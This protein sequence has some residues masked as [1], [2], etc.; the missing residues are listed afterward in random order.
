MKILVL[1]L[2]ISLVS[3]T[4]NAQA[5]AQSGANC[6]RPGSTTISSGKKYTCIKKG[7]AFVWNKGVA[8]KSRSTTTSTTT[9]PTTSTVKWQFDGKTWV[10]QGTAPACSMPVIAEGALLDFSRVKSIEQPGQVRGGSYK[11]HAAVRWSD[12]GSYVNGVSVTAPFDGEIVVAAQYKQGGNFQFLLNIIHPCGIMLR[13]G[14]LREPSDFVR[15]I[16]RKLPAAVEM[17]SR[18][19]SLSGVYIKKGQLIAS[20][21]GM[22]SPTQPD[23]HGSFID[24]GLVDLRSRNASLPASFS[25]NADTKYSTYSVCWYEGAYLSNADRAK[26][27]VLPFSSGISSSDYCTRR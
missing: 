5:T 3:V 19:T 2:S 8:V 6:K 26:V 10:A 22:D 16:L 17:D 11:P 24:F 13:I 9:T 21:V 4:N 20:E 25:S 12:Y 23:M 15:D 18:E 27:S 7:K 1:A 14:H